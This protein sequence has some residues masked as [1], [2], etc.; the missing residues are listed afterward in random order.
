MLPRTTK[1]LLISN[2]FPTPG[3]P[4][5]GVFTAQLAKRLQDRCEL[6]VVCPLPWLPSWTAR[7]PLGRLRAFASAPYEYDTGRIHVHSPKYA[8]VPR[9][10]RLGAMSM[11][12]GIAPTVLRLHRQVRFDV[13][14]AHWLYPD[15][16]VST[17]LGRH[18]D[19]PVVLTAL[20]SDVNILL[21]N[22]RT[23]GTI[24]NALRDADAVTAKSA[25]LRR[26]LV[27]E[28]IPA[29]RV[30]VTG[31]GVDVDRF[32]VR[33]REA[34]ASALGL[35]SAE[36]RLLFVGKLA[37]V[38]G[39][40]YLLQAVVGLASS[41]PRFT[42]YM[43]G[44]GP[45]RASC[46]RIT[47]ELGL[48]PR[49]RFV[50]AQHPSAIPCWL[51]AADVLCLP[52][53]H[54]GCPNVVLEA[55]ASGRPVVASRVGGVPE[56]LTDATGIMVPPGDSAALEAALRRA[57]ALP[58]DA[59]AMRAHVLPQSWDRAADA[60]CAVYDRVIGA[61]AVAAAS[62]VPAFMPSGVRTAPPQG[63]EWAR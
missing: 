40:K 58:W 26:R 5:R 25:G 61:R 21:D 55:L 56:L 17:W 18:L 29:E 9:Q 51:G 8:L 49:V 57:L 34:S 12:L 2:L 52:S 11:L 20:G 10:P 4:A 35:P 30:S 59:P 46:E 60:Y 48:L 33:D 6:T 54:E 16:V 43:V 37:S 44:E 39:V 15:G 63:G 3:D 14:N 47:R 7:A 24:V 28:G 38:K 13:I 22:P 62:L 23:H 53:L 1:V 50:G 19:V 36:R 42:L 45:E 32:T 41:N 31:N 27:Q